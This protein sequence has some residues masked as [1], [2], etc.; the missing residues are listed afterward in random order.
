MG[1]KKNVIQPNK[2]SLFKAV[3]DKKMHEMT[4]RTAKFVAA[5]TAA[6]KK[7]PAI[8]PLM[9]PTPERPRLSPREFSC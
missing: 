3:K 5:I 2:Y 7:V 4:K 6:A 9:Q 1:I 8:K